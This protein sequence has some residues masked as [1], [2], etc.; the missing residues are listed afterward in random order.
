[1]MHFKTILVFLFLSLAA[2]PLFS[3]DTLLLMNGMEMSCRITADTGTVFVVSMKNKRGKE[4]VREVYKLDVF[5]VTYEGKEEYILYEMNEPLG[6]IYT[7]DEMRFYLAGQKDAR[8]NFTAWPTFFVGF[9]LCGGIAF[10]GQDG[11][12]TAVAPPL[13]YT[14]VQLIPKIKIR[15][16]TMSHPDYKYND[17]YADGYEPPARSRKLI[18]ATEGAF[19]GSAAGVLTWFLFFRK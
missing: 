14:L 6:D 3:Q 15:E 11:F 10:A 18:R 12:I 17:L 13:I 1:M 8:M 4:K 2:Q 5:S 7:I 16:S 19:A 9:A